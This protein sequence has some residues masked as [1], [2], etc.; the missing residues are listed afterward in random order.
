MV[1]ASLL[2]NEVRNAEA[3]KKVIGM[4]RVGKFPGFEEVLFHVLGTSAHVTP[5]CLGLAS[6]TR[7]LC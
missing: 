5:F 6:H 1:A 4:I 7:F 2:Q 3:M